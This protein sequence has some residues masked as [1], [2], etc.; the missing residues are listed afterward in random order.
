MVVRLRADMPPLLR[1]VYWAAFGNPCCA[2]Y[3]P[4]YL[5]GCQ[6]PTNYAV[7]SST[8][9]ADSPWWQ[10]ARV[11]LLCDLNY[12][13]LQPKV[14]EVF[15]PTEKWIMERAEQHEVDAIRLLRDGRDAA[16]VERLQRLVDEDCVRIQEQ[17]AALNRTLPGM[18]EKAGIRYLYTDYL[19][20]WAKK[21]GVPLVEF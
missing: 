1:Q 3:Q 14:R 18:L 9:S 16:A 13:T 15:D 5:H 19:K 2:V 21:S 20:D 8:W 7:G 6:V 10:A 12:P 11:R 4:F 17:C